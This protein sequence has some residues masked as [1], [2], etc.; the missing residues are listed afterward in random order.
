MQIEARTGA[1][2]G[3]HA[4]GRVEIVPTRAEIEAVRRA[5]YGAAA[6]V[7]QGEAAGAKPAA[8][9][10]EREHG[11]WLVRHPA[12]GGGVKI[13]GA[14]LGL[15]GLMYFVPAWRHPLPFALTCLLSFL[16]AVVIHNHMHRGIFTRSS[17][18]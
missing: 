1:G 8:H 16:N 4:P 14:Y 12:S 17:S 13:V 2:Q 10:R 18:T 7:S 15:M 6:M 3:Y 5:Q 11:T 9:E